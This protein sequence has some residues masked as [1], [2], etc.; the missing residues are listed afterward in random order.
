MTRAR[1]VLGNASL[2][3]RFDAVRQA[4]IGTVRAAESLRTEIVE[5]RAKVA[6]AHG[7]K[8]EKFDVKHSPGGMVDVEFAVQFL[9][10][11]QASIHP[12]LLANV[13]NIA[14]LQRTQDCGL[15]PAPV[16][17]A[18]ARAYRVLRQIQ[19]QARL[20]EEPTQVDL[21][22]AETERA[23]GLALWH[24]VFGLA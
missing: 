20:N 12:E 9:V 13:G 8:G 17:E 3:Q 18:A 4:V 16:G 11:S 2:H 6:A 24:A 7:V 15:L 22:S 21:A 23:A 1:C 19:H 14:L 5:M 10:L